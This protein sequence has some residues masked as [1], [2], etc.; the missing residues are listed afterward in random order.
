MQPK[1]FGNYCLVSWINLGTRELTQ[2]LAC[3]TGEFTIGLIVWLL[4]INDM[5][6]RL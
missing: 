2:I 6:V 3:I 5:L 1:P 4:F